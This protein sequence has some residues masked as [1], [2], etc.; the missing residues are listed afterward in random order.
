MFILYKNFRG[1]ECGNPTRMNSAE[2][3]HTMMMV[4]NV[5]N[6]PLNYEEVSCLVL[7]MDS[8]D[9]SAFQ[10][11]ANLVV[12]K[13]KDTEICAGR[14]GGDDDDDDDDDDS[15]TL[16]ESERNS[17]YNQCNTLNSKASKL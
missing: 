11:L 3:L 13:S 12:L 2:M 17:K 14:G 8:D 9:T 10:R 6:D 5:Q 15:N 1:W 4:L 16:T 7:S